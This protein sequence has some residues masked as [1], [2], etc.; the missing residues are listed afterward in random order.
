MSDDVEIKIGVDPSTGQ[1]GVAALSGSFQNE[2]AKIRSEIQSI[3]GPV[4]AILKP[5]QNAASE[6]IN[7]GAGAIKAEGGIA[8]LSNVVN[9]AV[10]GFTALVGMMIGVV[11]AGFA[12]AESAAKTV[13]PLKEI[14]ETT[15]ISVSTLSALNA[16]AKIT[17]TTV[18]ALG[19]TFLRFEKILGANSDASTDLGK[20]L[21]QMGV[22]TNDPDQAIQKILE[23][24]G[25]MPAGTE[26]S[27][28]AFELFSRSS[29]AYLK[30][31][32]Q[33]AKNGGTFDQ[34]KQKMEE[35]GTLMTDGNAT[36]ALLFEQSLTKIQNRIGGLKTKLGVELIPTFQELLDGVNSWLTNYGPNLASDIQSIAGFIEGCVYIL[37]VIYAVIESYIQLLTM[38]I[39]NWV[40]VFKTAWEVVKNV[41]SAVH[42]LWRILKGDIDG[43]WAE[44]K[45]S[46][47]DAW[48]AIKDGISNVITNVKAY[49]S[50]VSDNFNLSKG[51]A[52]AGKGEGDKGEGDGKKKGSAAKNTE[53]QEQERL[54]ALEL[55]SHQA[56]KIYQSET[57]SLQI[58]FDQR[59]ISAE[60][61]TRDMIKQADDLEA[62]NA[63]IYADE[64]EAI[65]NSNMKA[66]AKVNAIA[67]VN[68]KLDENHIEHDKKVEKLQADHQ[69]VL[70]DAERAHNQAMA[71]IAD[72]ADKAEIDSIKTLIDNK[73]VT[74]EQGEIKI[75]AIEQR[76]FDRRRKLL[77]D[78]LKAAGA[79]LQERQKVKDSLAKLDEDQAVGVEN[80]GRRKQA[81]RKRDL[82]DEEKYREQMAHLAEESLKLD[83]D[84]D[85]QRVDKMK[86]SG[87]SRVE[88]ARAEADHEKAIQNESYQQAKDG[89][90][91]S[92]AAMLAAAGTNEKK[93]A[94]VEKQ[95]SD[96][97]LKEQ[98]KHD[99][100][101]Q[102]ID[103]ALWKK[104]QSWNLRSDQSVFGVAY[105][106]KLAATG[107]K[108]QAWGAMIGGVLQN[109]QSQ[110]KSFQDM[111]QAATDTMVSGSTAMLK[112][113]I[114][115]GDAGSQAFRKMATNIIESIAQ[116][117][118]VNAINAT[119]WGIWDL[120][121]DPPQAAAD[122]AAAAEWFGGAA[123][124]GLAGRAVAGNSF[125]SSSGSSSGSSSPGGGAVP[126]APGSS[127]SSDQTK[128]I[129]ETGR[130]QQPQVIIFH[131]DPSVTIQHVTSD[132]LKNG[133]TRSMIRTDIFGGPQR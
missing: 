115:T 90:D 68:E 114:E 57:E 30:I 59:K 11:A 95:Y 32:D 86:A 119:A 20:K 118:L 4:I 16:M 96:L 52:G 128:T 24:L 104:L 50:A 65:N 36:A 48:G 107:S 82:D 47:V 12:L 76:S 84:L 21:L 89:L 15:G 123:I 8:S 67:A 44:F 17:K 92:E 46:G 81:A 109:L 130:N 9:I 19:P 111:F 42:G 108:W 41:A 93:R 97:R 51:G 31:A 5:I 25:Q 61:F 54:K 87:A 14:S 66:Q 125:S 126:S 7:I 22:D 83:L 45:A 64:I 101:I 98:Q 72:T 127:K 37:R 133:P 33:L 88:I 113:W 77:N 105:A 94:D 58:E 106:D 27:T 18:E 35:N 75:A 69:K 131:S 6:L 29:G 91:K 85:Q 117:M 2:F 73:T 26:R 122:F 80:S 70:Q 10:L 49:G 23:H 78:D 43:G 103:D 100:Q 112:S 102:Q 63:A 3:L 39:Q 38:F 74:N 34:L 1:A 129:Y 13:A 121:W 62:H 79:N 28:L 116:M 99:N 60:A 124:A 56:Q 55:A 53:D 110:T 40:Q 132:Y 71:E 120:F